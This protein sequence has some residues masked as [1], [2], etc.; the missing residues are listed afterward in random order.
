MPATAPPK[1]ANL[2]DWSKQRVLLVGDS[3]SVGLKNPLG[4][5]LKEA[6]ATFEHVGRVGSRIDQW[7]SDKKDD[8]K[9]L[10]K[11]LASFKPTVVIVSLGTNDEAPR[12]IKKQYDVW[13]N[14]QAAF[15]VLTAK[16]GNSRV[17]WL[18]PPDNDFMDPAFRKSMAAAVGEDAYF[19]PPADLKKGKDRLHPIPAAYKQWAAAAMD[20]LKTRTDKTGVSGLGNLAMISRS[21]LRLPARLRP[22]ATQPIPLPPSMRAIPKTQYGI[23][24][25]P[26][27]RPSNVS[28]TPETQTKPV[29]I[30]V[31]SR[32]LFGFGYFGT[33]PRMVKVIRAT[34][35]GQAFEP[36]TF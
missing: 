3:L 9:N 33:R 1:A 7:A 29:P 36:E 14:Q 35:P 31:V 22:R 30:I 32:P 5:L 34:R 11:V 23:G 2:I 4:S 15:K 17:L 8:G 18:G 21:R 25:R 12:K 16:F 24:Q 13:K 10:N 6:G 28:T 20:W 19:V 27:L 26:T